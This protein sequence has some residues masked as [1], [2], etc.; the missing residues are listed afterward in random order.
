MAAIAPIVMND[1]LAVA[2]TFTPAY[3]KG[4]LVGWQE[5][6]LPT[7]NLF[8]KLTIGMRDSVGSSSNR[9]VTFKIVVP[10]NVTVDG[11]TTTKNVSYFVESVAPADAPSIALIDA[12]TYLYYAFNNAVIIDTFDTG[13]FPY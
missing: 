7:Y 5:E 13:K 4:L 1:S 6:S 11:V 8:P 12:R 10:Y 2:R 9:K 3:Q